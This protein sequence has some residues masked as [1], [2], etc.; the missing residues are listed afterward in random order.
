MFISE[1]LT[2]C[3]YVSLH[4]KR[5]FADVFKIRNFNGGVSLDCSVELS[6]SMQVEERGREGDMMIQGGRNHVR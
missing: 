1:S 3:I 2:L 5:H 6:G 4:G